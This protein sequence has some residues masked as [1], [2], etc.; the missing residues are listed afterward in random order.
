M[1]KHIFLSFLFL[2]VCQ[3]QQTNQTYIKIVPSL[4]DCQNLSEICLT[5][6]QCLGSQENITFCFTSNIE[7]QFAAGEHLANGSVEYLIIEDI[8]Y[9][10][11]IGETLDERPAARIHCNNTKAFAILHSNYV[12][13]TGL[14]FCG[15]GS[16]VPTN[17]QYRAFN[18]YTK[19]YLFTP[20]PLK[21]AI[22][23]VHIVHLDL[24]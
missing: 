22:F 21:A 12:L 18:V 3:S 5:L 4:N 17:V 10:S 14:E 2:A 8:N 24:E 15:C 23:L 19:A 16:L 7:L 13:I 6:S 9:L 20:T 1:W 11:L